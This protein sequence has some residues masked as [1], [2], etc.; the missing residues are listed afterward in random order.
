M[1]TELALQKENIQELK[2]F[3]IQEVRL[4]TICKYQIY[5]Y[6]FFY[7]PLESRFNSCVGIRY[8]ANDAIDL[9]SSICRLPSCCGSCT[10]LSTAR[11]SFQNTLQGKSLRNAMRVCFQR[12]LE[13]PVGSTVSSF[14]KSS[15]AE[16]QPRLYW[17]TEPHNRNPDSAHS[18]QTKLSTSFCTK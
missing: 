2:T 9:S 12:I 17:P 15:V 1:S 13:C 7:Y 11:D 8:S 16:H 5:K 4:C 14:C 10:C 18:L 3:S 6:T